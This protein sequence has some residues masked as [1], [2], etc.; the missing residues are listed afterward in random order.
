MS[1]IWVV[2]G[3]TGE[4]SDRSEWPVKAFRDQEVAERFA[5]AAKVRADEIEAT[6]DALQASGEW[7]N[8]ADQALVET[9]ELDPDMSMDYTGTDYYAMGPVELE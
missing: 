5:L 7:N 6:R 3:T 9:N 4:Y 8:A 1:D 2:M